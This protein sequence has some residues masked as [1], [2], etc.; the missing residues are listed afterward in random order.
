MTLLQRDQENQDIGVKQGFDQGLKQGLM[1]LIEV[2]KNYTHDGEEIYKKVTSVE[3]YRHVT[4]E[5]VFM[6]L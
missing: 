1:I 2:L 5:D 4:R 6:Y 3:V